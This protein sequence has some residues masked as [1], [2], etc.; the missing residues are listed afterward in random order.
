MKFNL[1][2]LSLGA[3]L[4]GGN[5]SACYTA[6]AKPADAP[7]ADPLAELKAQLAEQQK[8]IAAQSLQ[9]AELKQ[10][11]ERPAEP[12]APPSML[13]IMADGAGVPLSDVTWRVQAGLDPDQAILAAIA[14]KQSNE[15]EAARKAEA[16]RKAA[17]AKSAEATVRPQ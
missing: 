1:I 17:E 8:T 11:A 3:A 15:A 6:N 2:I 14:Q 9:L 7:P 5:A 4:F 16:L 10:A 12:V 13:K